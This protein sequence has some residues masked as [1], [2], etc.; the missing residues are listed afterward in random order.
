ME[1]LEEILSPDD[2]QRYLELKRKVRE[3]KYI[4]QF[5]LDK[6]HSFDCDTAFTNFRALLNSGLIQDYIKT[7]LLEEES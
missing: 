7:L 5:P 4:K 3:G 2:Y 6:K 1:K